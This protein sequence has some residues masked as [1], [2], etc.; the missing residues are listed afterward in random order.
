M[1]STETSEKIFWEDIVVG[2]TIVTREEIV[3]FAQA[4]DPQPFHLDDEA[5]KASI[6]GRLCASGWHS[7]AMMMRMVA[8]GFLNTA[9]SLGSP[10]MDEVKWIKPVFPGDTLSGRYTCHAKRVLSSRPH[11]GL[12]QMLFE[13]LNQDNNVVMTW[14]IAQLIG[15][16]NPRARP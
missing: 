13:M 4:F 14:S 8:D 3:A 9:A 5:A 7:C 11:V 10:G 15:L 16:R 12:C 1:N 6:V 2:R